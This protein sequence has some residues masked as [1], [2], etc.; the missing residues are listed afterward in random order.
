[1]IFHSY[2]SLPEG[3]PI[4]RSPRFSAGSQSTMWPRNVQPTAWPD[5]AYRHPRWAGHAFYAD[6]LAEWVNQQWP[7]RDNQ[8]SEK[9]GK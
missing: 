1:M 8:V 5:W 3:T 9:E 2:L 4:K 6:M 7:S